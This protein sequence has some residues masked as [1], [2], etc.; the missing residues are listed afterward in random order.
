[1]RCSKGSVSGS[2]ARSEEVYAI[3]Y[4]DTV[5][6]NIRDEGLVRNKAVYLAIGVSGAGRKESWV[7]GSS[8]PRGRS[9]GC[10]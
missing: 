1:M 3:V 2:L 7:Y 10:R 9:S 8:T 6:V 5:R 4:F